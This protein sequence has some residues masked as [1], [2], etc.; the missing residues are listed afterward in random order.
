MCNVTLFNIHLCPCKDITCPRV[1]PF[2]RDA[3][4]T[5]KF[6]ARAHILSADEVVLPEGLPCMTCF[7]RHTDAL[8]ASGGGDFAMAD[9]AVRLCPLLNPASL[10]NG[11]VAVAPALCPEC[12]AGC[13]QRPPTEQMIR[14]HLREK[15]EWEEASERRI[16]AEAR[17]A[18]AA[19]GRAL[20]RAQGKEKR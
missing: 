17:R 9:A 19:R 11:R 14:A 10:A 3:A 2:E 5:G 1:R 16:K 4:Y 18:E 6:P 12:S 13:D 8:L 7:A 15:R 20:K